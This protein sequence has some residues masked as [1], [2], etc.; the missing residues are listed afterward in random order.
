MISKVFYVKGRYIQAD[1][2][3]A[4]GFKVIFIILL[5]IGLMIIGNKINLFLRI[6]ISALI[7]LFLF[8]YSKL[9]SF[10]FNLKV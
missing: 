9:D 6:Y 5:L 7:L 8:N 10:L 4:G 2:Y 3:Q 1:V